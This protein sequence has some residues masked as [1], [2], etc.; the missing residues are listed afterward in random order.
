MLSESTIETR[1]YVGEVTD[2]STGQIL[3]CPINLPGLLSF[4][5]NVTG[6][7]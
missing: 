4:M 3:G 2:S 1:A 6:N 7:H 5:E